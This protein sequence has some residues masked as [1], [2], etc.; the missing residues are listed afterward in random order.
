MKY[1]FGILVMAIS[2][3]GC[4]A[5]KKEMAE[6]PE[7]ETPPKIQYDESFDPLSLDDDDIRIGPRKNATDSQEKSERS[8]IETIES[9]IEPGSYIETDGYRV[10]IFA[11]RSI[12]AAT[13]EQQKAVELFEPL[14]HKVY[15]IF[16]APYYKL[17]IG[18]V[19][20][21]RDADE[22][23]DLAK[24]LGYDQ[25]FPMTSKIRVAGQA[26]QETY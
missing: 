23:R 17:R 12:E 20:Q 8:T 10:Q 25:A 4:A 19:K 18:D 26:Q 15:L 5:S 16:E 14:K 13:I 21:R 24:S 9:E 11:T 7:K 2:L 3:A 22:L 1:I 6:V